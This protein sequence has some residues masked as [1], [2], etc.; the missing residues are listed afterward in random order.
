[1]NAEYL[2][3]QFRVVNPIGYLSG[4]VGRQMYITRYRPEYCV[5]KFANEHLVGDAKILGL[6]L[7]AGIIATGK[8]SLTKI[9][10]PLLLLYRRQLME[11]VR[12][13]LI[14]DLPMSWSTSI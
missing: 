10:F 5:M 3:D 7:A 2:V 12:R 8:S 6:Y 13:W 9:F 1:M 14:A 11:S 4:K